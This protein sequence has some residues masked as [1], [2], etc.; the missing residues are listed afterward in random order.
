MYVTA[1]NKHAIHHRLSH[2]SCV[3][4]GALCT[5]MELQAKHDCSELHVCNC[6]SEIFFFFL[7]WFLCKNDVLQNVLLQSE[8]SGSLCWYYSYFY[9]LP[10]L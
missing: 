3:F 8:K 9:L 7:A 1:T 6:D 5:L 2:A 10:M 4:S